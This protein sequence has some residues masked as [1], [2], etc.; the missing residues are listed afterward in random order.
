VLEMRRKMS[1]K[2]EN[3]QL[4]NNKEADRRD[5]Q[6]SGNEQVPAE[7]GGHRCLH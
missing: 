4:R 5:G 6:L 7:K 3:W 1:E 2:H